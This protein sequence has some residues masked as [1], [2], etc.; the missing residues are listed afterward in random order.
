MVYLILRTSCQPF[1]KQQKTATYAIN[2]PTGESGVEDNMYNS[3]L[4]Q[5]TATHNVKDSRASIVNDVSI[6]KNIAEWRGQ[7]GGKRGK[8]RVRNIMGGVE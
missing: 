3:Q 7:R 2:Y 8:K 6:G 4:S 5:Q 1:L